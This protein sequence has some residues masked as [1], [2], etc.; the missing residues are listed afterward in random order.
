MAR[1]L[2]RNDTRACDRPVMIASNIYYEIADRRGQPLGAA[3]LHT[4]GNELPPSAGAAGFPPVN[5]DLGSQGTGGLSKHRHSRWY[6]SSW[7]PARTARELREPGVAGAAG[8]VG[9]GTAGAAGIQ[10]RP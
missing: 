9:A 7:S 4:V 8:A 6:C 10:L 1:R 3:G 5:G 2:D